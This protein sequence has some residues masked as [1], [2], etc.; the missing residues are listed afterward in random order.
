[1]NAKKLNIAIFGLG[2]VGLPLALEFGKKFNTIGFDINKT[3]V[4]ELKL[5]IDTNLLSKR[6]D[7]I[8]SKKLSFSSNV[9]NLNNSNI[10]IITVPTPVSKNNKPDL[11]YLRSA[12]KI[13]GSLLKKRN[14]VIYESTVY[15]GL[16]EEECVPILEKVSKL[17]INK[18]FFV[19]YSPERISPGDN[20]GLKD[21]SKIVSGSNEYAARFVYNLYKKIIKAEVFKAKS[22]K[23]AEAAKVIENAQR[24]I[25]I[26]FMNEISLIFS[27]LEINTQDVL[28][29][30]STKW[31]FLKFK[32]GL[33]GGH[34]ISVDPYYLTYKAKK[35][36]YTPQVILSGRK[37][38][39]N[40][41][42]YISNLLLKKLKKNYL[43]ISKIKI[44]IMGVTFKE[45]CN[46]LRGSKV[47]DII[48][49]LK[50]SGAEVLIYDPIVKNR[51]FNK[52]LPDI[53][54][55]KITKKVDALIIAV[56][57]KEFLKLKISDLKNILRN[58][59][60]ILMD[61]KSIFRDD[62]IKNSFDYWSL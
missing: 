41:G 53:K 36:G 56:S 12:S 38:N 28:E 40:M 10:F 19:G 31:N 25:N 16:T 11:K 8:K 54:I 50:K 57:H 58:K 2:Y 1:M 24:D 43:N 4:S 9:E 59:N 26:S 21:I 22:I 39:E 17:K 32:P 33:V 61:V 52:Y 23:I 34:C 20:K 42:H 46:D 18:D 35:V 27:K 14:F 55:K 3:R 62:K 51:E 60:S 44:G 37:I 45:N 49:D 15:P 6:E 30:A 7:F 47:I 48:K 29:A 13:V 5:K